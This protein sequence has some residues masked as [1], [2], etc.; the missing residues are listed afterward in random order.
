VASGTPAALAAKNV[1]RTVPIV[2]V[3]VNDPVGTGLVA[4]LAR[5]G[6]NIT[7]L[8]N[9]TPDLAMKRVELLK[10]VVPQLSRLRSWEIQPIR[11]THPR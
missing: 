8:T 10:E 3:A 2:F 6:E 1:T 4:S 5:P 7:G 9:Q 11:R